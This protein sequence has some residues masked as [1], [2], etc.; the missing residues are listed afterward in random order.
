VSSSYSPVID[1]N[2]IRTDSSVATRYGVI[3][4][5]AARIINNT[6]HPT[7]G[8]PSSRVQIFV[9]NAR[10]KPA[11]RFDIVG[12]RFDLSSGGVHD[13]M[14][15]LAQRAN[16]SNYAFSGSISK[17]YFGSDVTPS[18]ALT[19]ADVIKIDYYVGSMDISDNMFSFTTSTTITDVFDFSLAAKPAN[20]AN[21]FIRLRDN[22][23]QNTFN[24]ATITRLI[25]GSST[26]RITI[27]GGDLSYSYTTTGDKQPD[28]T[29]VESISVTSTVAA[30]VTNFTGGVNGQTIRVTVVG[31]NITIVDGTP[32]KLAGSANFAPASGGVI[33]LTLEG[34]QWREVSRTS[35]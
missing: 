6:F 31:G 32:I 16:Q 15:H 27:N 3:A 2:W 13:Q 34:T 20:Y 18:N 1:S 26:G 25:A 10:G 8:N 17:N 28:V 21:T 7:N 14:I 19:I 22:Q 9:Q 33:T 30:N 11:G 4:S 12:N 5:Q 23:I 24:Q 35:Y 29:I